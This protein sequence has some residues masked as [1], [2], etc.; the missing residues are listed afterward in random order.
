MLQ[1]FDDEL[2]LRDVLLG[3]HLRTGEPKAGRPTA[4]TSWGS[5][6]EGRGTVQRGYG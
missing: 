3:I 1:R 5:I 4:H 2:A 6:S